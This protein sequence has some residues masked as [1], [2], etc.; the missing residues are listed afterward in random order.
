M[1]KRQGKALLVLV[2]GSLWNCMHAMLT[3][4]VRI[5]TTITNILMAW[6]FQRRYN[7]N[8]LYSRDL[9]DRQRENLAADR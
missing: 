8:P 3:F 6:G 1:A 4:D 5:R 2:G 7:Q 9:H